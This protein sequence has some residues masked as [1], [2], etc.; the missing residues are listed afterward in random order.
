MPLSKHRE[1]IEALEILVES[2]QKGY[3]LTYA[4]QEAEAVLHQWYDSREHPSSIKRVVCSTCGTRMF[5][6]NISIPD[7]EGK[8]RCDFCEHALKMK[9]LEDLKE[10]RK[11]SEKKKWK[12]NKVEAD[13]RTRKGKE[14]FVEQLR[15]LSDDEIVEF[16]NSVSH[17]EAQRFRQYLKKY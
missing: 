5:H 11:G 16:L 3:I 15:K 6:E 13:E 12:G 17:S 10:G 8:T 7:E 1:A 14:E 4:V 9:A 2:L